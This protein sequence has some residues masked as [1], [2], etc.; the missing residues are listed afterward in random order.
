MTLYCLIIA[1]HRNTV[2]HHSSDKTGEA[3][4]LCRLSHSS[5]NFMNDFRKI[6]A[7]CN[8]TQFILFMTLT[9]SVREKRKKRYTCSYSSFIGWLVFKG[10]SY[11]AGQIFLPHWSIILKICFMLYKL[12]IGH[13]ATGACIS[14]VG[15]GCFFKI[16][17]CSYVYI[18]RKLILSGLSDISDDVKLIGRVHI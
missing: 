1:I 5:G 4:F 15:G 14:W 6:V 11:I 9:V 2:T 13:A 10:I 7:N 17:N 8:F 18:Y 3:L 16:E 12:N